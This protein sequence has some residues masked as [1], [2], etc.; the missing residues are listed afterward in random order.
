M[1]VCSLMAGRPAENQIEVTG[2]GAEAGGRD[3]PGADDDVGVV[4]AD[5]GIV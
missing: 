5:V 3:L 2:L 1:E 4:V